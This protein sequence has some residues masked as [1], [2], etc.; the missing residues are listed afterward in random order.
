MF[1]CPN[2]Y[3]IRKTILNLLEALCIARESIL[4]RFELRRKF[5]CEEELYDQQTQIEHVEFMQNEC[6][7]NK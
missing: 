3:F 2:K 5:S 1:F 7:Q 4:I 6:E